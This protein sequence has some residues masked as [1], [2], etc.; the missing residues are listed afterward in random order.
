M[1]KIIFI[2]LAFVLSIN[3]YAKANIEKQVEKIRKEFVKINSEKNY[4]VETVGRPESEKFIEY[5]RKNKQLKKVVEYYNIP[6]E[7]I[8]IQYYLK[9]NEVFFTYKIERKYEI[10]ETGEN[11]KIGES[12]KRYYFNKGDLIR[13]IEDGKIYDKGNIPEKYK[14]M[15]GGLPKTASELEN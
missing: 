10:K 13:Y 8:I 12:Q 9:S 1:K 15:A 14:E 11:I 7:V 3:I 2:V 4:E 5:Y 6:N